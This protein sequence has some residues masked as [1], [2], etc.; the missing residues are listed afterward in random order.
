MRRS[1][2]LAAFAAVLCIIAAVP[3]ASP[4]CAAIVARRDGLRAR[5]DRCEVA[6]RECADA[7]ACRRAR[8]I[9]EPCDTA[10]RACD[11]AAASG[12]LCGALAREW[13]EVAGAWAVE[14]AK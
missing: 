11:I 2:L 9:S 3:A 13:R 14:C 10:D 12:M 4:D 6:V 1:L 8:V 7:T 5:L